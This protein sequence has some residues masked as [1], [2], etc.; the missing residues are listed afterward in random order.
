MEEKD[1]ISEMIDVVMKVARGDYSVKVKLSET[2]DDFDALAIGINMMIGDIRDK[3]QEIKGLMQIEKEAAAVKAAAD[4]EKKKAEELHAAN[5][6]LRASEQQMKAANQQLAAK[7]EAL[8][9]SQDELKKKVSDLE[10]FNKL[11]VGRELDMVKLKE[12]VNSLLEKAGE[13][14]KYKVA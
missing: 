3:I 4:I 5:Q 1:R 14:K 11:M 8:R 10:R 2:N 9:G 12:E 7:E 6:Q 13:P